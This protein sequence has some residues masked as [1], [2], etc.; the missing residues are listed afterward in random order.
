MWPPFDP[1]GDGTILEDISRNLSQSTYLYNIRK[2]SIDPFA[3]SDA[4][5]KFL[6]DSF[7]IMFGSF[8]K[9]V[10]MT[11]HVKRYIDNF[12]IQNWYN[13][14]GFLDPCRTNPVR[15]RW[16]GG[17]FFDVNSA[18]RIPGRIGNNNRFDI[19]VSKHLRKL[20]FTGLPASAFSANPENPVQ[21]YLLWRKEHGYAIPEISLEYDGA[22]ESLNL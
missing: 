22:V 19:C 3:F 17:R 14:L 9:L 5:T 10:D 15:E 11:V 18:D 13:L 20:T 16:M 6:S 7:C 1:F 21:K 4:C 2:I 12:S 8:P